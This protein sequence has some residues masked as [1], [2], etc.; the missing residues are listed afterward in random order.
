VF[1]CVCFFV[2]GGENGG[3]EEQVKEARGFFL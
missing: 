2:V 1:V 3:K